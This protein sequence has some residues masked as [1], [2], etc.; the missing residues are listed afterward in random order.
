MSKPSGAQRRSRRKRR[1][2]NR[3][4]WVPPGLPVT[5]QGYRLPD[6]MVFLGA[7]QETDF[8]GPPKPHEL[9]C[10]DPSLSVVRPL[11][12]PSAQ[13][14]PPWVSYARLTPQDRARYLNWLAHGRREPK[15]P[16]GLVRRFLAG[17]ERRLLVF[18][19]SPPPRREVDALLARHAD[20]APDDDPEAA[21]SLR[22]LSAEI[23]ERTVRGLN[24]GVPLRLVALAGLFDLPAPL[25][26]WADERITSIIPAPF[27]IALWAVLG[28]VNINLADIATFTIGRPSVPAKMLAM[29]S[30][31]ARIRRPGWG[32][33]L[34]IVGSASESMMTL[35][36]I[37][38]S[39]PG[40][41]RPTVPMRLSSGWLTVAPAEFS[42]MP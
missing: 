2:G 22:R 23:A 17:L 32:D 6:G 20:E 18:H 9:V 35:S 8:W 27:S 11:T 4:D 25:L 12:G 19:H 30:T 10:I 13:D 14:R 1:K 7:S 39:A 41:A 15:A 38:T 5:I 26:Q 3:L 16:L 29:P 42:V 36:P 40:K 24:D 33:L 28:G 34:P 31:P 37:F 21:S